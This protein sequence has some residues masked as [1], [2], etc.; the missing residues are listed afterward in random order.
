MNNFQKLQAEEE[1]LFKQ[2]NKDQEVRNRLQ[3]TMGF[4]QFIGNIVDVYVP[5]VMDC[6][7]V[8]IGGEL[9]ENIPGGRPQAPSTKIDHRLRAPKPDQPDVQGR[10]ELF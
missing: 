1:L 10:D 3:G 5:K 4:F 7:I 8:T 6:L 9:Q 2:G